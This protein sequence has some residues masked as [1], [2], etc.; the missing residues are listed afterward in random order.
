MK[1][2]R[3]PALALCAIIS[4]YSCKK[5]DASSGGVKADPNPPITYLKTGNKWVYNITGGILA[6]SYSTSTQEITANNNGI[7]TLA[8]TFDN[9]KST[10]FE[11]YSNGFLCTYDDGESIGPDQP[12]L[13]FTNAQ[14]GDK[15]TRITPSET[16]YHELESL[17]ESVTVPAGTFICKKIKTTFKNAFND[18]TSYWS[19]QYGEIKIEGLSAEMELASKNF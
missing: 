3:I 14:V 18:Q 15:W 19:D 12:I 11:Y 4:L 2:V 10:A 8:V 7:F 9:D 13:K 17:N 1:K 5:D 16:Y 6:F